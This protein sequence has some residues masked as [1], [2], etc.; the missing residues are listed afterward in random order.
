MKL[1]ELEKNEIK[2]DPSL[3][4]VVQN[5]LSDKSIIDYR[6]KKQINCKILQGSVLKSTF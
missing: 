3:I 1:K 6:D 5:Y 4:N 2:L